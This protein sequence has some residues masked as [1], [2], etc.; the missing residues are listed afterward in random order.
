MCIHGGVDV[1]ELLI[2]NKPEKIEEEV[3][4]IIDLWGNRGGMIIA[5]AHEIEPETPIENIIAI[6]KAVNEHYR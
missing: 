2:F 1:K 6:Y 4:K 5:P 3:R